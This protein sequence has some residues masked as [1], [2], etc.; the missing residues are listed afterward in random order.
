[1]SSK[2]NESYPKWNVL[3]QVL[4]FGSGDGNYLTD[5]ASKYIFGNKCPD[6][7]GCCSRSVGNS[8]KGGDYCD[9]SNSFIPLSVCGR[10]SLDY[11]DGN[12][13]YFSPAAAADFLA[14]LISAT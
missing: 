10:K 5:L 9:I 1:M 2:N 6:D 7:H 8:Y 11:E 4:R 3:K 14:L 13:N 12:N